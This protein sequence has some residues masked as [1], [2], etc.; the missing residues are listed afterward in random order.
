[1]VQLEPSLI[2]S[3]IFFDR[4]KNNG[5]KLEKLVCSK[6][7][8]LLVSLFVDS[9]FNG[10]CEGLAVVIGFDM[11][12]E[13]LCGTERYDYIHTNMVYFGNGANDMFLRTCGS[14]MWTKDNEVASFF[15]Y[16]NNVGTMA[17]SPIVDLLIKEGYKL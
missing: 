17:Y 1:M 5:T 12:P 11:F 3:T 15:Q 14:A 10:K 2:Y 16:C 7:V 13:E 8:P 4:N 9:T 6:E